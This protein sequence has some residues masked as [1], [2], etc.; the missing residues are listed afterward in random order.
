ML[1]FSLEVSQKGTPST[2]L[3]LIVV[4]QRIG[5]VGRYNGGSC[6]SFCSWVG[7]VVFIT[8][9]DLLTLGT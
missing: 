5:H 1:F 2:I 6:G 4:D 9:I 3:M 7:F 8:V